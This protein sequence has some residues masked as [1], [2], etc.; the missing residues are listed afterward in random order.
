[1]ERF[2]RKATAEDLPVALDLIES[3]RKSWQRQDFST[4]ASSI[5]L[6]VMS[7]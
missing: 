2:V 3:G 4:V 1:M 6:M 5:C 7:G